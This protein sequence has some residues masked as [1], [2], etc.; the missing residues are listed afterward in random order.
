MS[1][2]LLGLL[3]GTGLGLLD[4]LSGVLYPELG[5]ILARVILISTLKGVIAGFLIGIVAQGLHSMWRGV[6]TGFGVGTLLSYLVTLYAGPALFWDIVLPGMLLGVIV[7]FATQRYGR[8][9]V[10]AA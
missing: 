9:P 6:A 1:K 8:A 4:G 7:G 2:P 5:P 10:P 3:L